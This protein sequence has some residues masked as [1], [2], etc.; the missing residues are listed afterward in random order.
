[1]TNTKNFL[2]FFL[3]FQYIPRLFLIFPLSTQIVKATGLV[4]QTAW[5]GAAYNLILLSIERQ[6]AC[7]RT[8]CK[9]DKSCNNGFFDC[10]KIDD[11]QRGSWFRTSNIKNT[12]NP[13]DPFY[14]F[15]IYGDSITFHV[16]TSPFF[17]K[18]FYC[19]WWGLKN[20]R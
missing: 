4:T 7:W 18:Y 6:E 3:I 17:N 10:H 1:M 9:F 15:G 19:L 2:R 14:Q 11:P 12:C 8:L 20:L 5:A 16:T 13:N